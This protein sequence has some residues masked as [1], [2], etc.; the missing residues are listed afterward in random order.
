MSYSFSLTIPF[1]ESYCTQLNGELTDDALIK[2]AFTKQ[3]K[4][5]TLSL[6]S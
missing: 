5:T 4:A 3:M 6:S 1:T 2:P